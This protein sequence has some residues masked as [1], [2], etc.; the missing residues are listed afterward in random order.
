MRERQNKEEP[1]GGI[2]L[3]ERA[4]SILVSVPF[5]AWCIYLAGV[6]PFGLISLYF[7]TDMSLSPFAEQ[8]IGVDSF[9][10]ALSA[11]WW[12]ACQARFGAALLSV[13]AP[14][15]LETWSRL[16]W[17]LVTFRQGTLFAV[18]LFLS[19]IALILVLPTGWLLSFFQESV[20]FGGKP[21]NT[22]QSLGQQSAAMTNVWQRQNHVALL[23]VSGFAL[24]VFL[25]TYS[26][27]F[28][29]PFV[30]RVFTGIETA[31]TQ[32]PL[33]ALNTTV[34]MV[35]CYLTYLVSSPLTRAIY[36]V[37][38]YHG[39]SLKSAQDLRD[40]LHFLRV[41]PI[42]P[43]QRLLAVLLALSAFCSTTA[44]LNAQGMDSS[45]PGDIPQATTTT[46]LDSAIDE[47]IQRPDFAWRLPIQAGIDS[48]PSKLSIWVRR[49]GR[50]IADAIEWIIESLRPE[51]ADRTEP[52]WF[53]GWLSPR[54]LLNILLVV[55][56]I[57]LGILLFRLVLRSRKRPIAT[58]ENVIVQA[59]PDVDNMET[60]ASDLPEEEWMRM[61]QEFA[62]SGD[63]RRAL[64]SYYL[65]CLAHLH[66][67]NFLR[68]TKF[69]S[70]AAYVREVNRHALQ[71][72]ELATEFRR[73]VNRFDRTWYGE[74]PIAK[75]DL[76]QSATWVGS[77]RGLS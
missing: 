18:F 23:V 27:V 53:E 61:A 33:I 20:L 34:L 29:L 9:L 51:P 32:S 30:L 21:S 55:V 14:I 39:H 17:I 38:H 47:V 25:N 8:R 63:H 12:R 11:L 1:F 37:R 50:W 6:I 76:E 43:Q 31:V 75:Q 69:K 7:F 57:T 35:V 58:T 68:I 71:S 60:L 28:F 66:E 19:P 49:M 77:I 13:W 74:Y 41:K 16:D 42:S 52:G 2:E 56:A 10:V 59:V 26:F 36:V 24:L 44:S 70:N 15:P 40:Q 72:P 4:V 65:S 48:G 73:L 3:I 67:A 54:P 5:S 62:A 64:R 22:V 45:K 46:E